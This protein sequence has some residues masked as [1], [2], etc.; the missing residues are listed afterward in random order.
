MLLDSFFLVTALMLLH[1]Y[2]H[3]VERHLLPTPIIINRFSQVMTHKANLSLL[4]FDNVGFKFE[5]GMSLLSCY[6][7]FLDLT[8]CNIVKTHLLMFSKQFS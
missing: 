3:N 8:Y 1:S 4:N 2:N 6:K 5:N 7:R